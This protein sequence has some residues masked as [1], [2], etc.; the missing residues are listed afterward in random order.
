MLLSKPIEQMTDK[1]LSDNAVIL[2]AA[3]RA[4][5]RF[6]H[7][8]KFQTIVTR[9]LRDDVRIEIAER[10]NAQL[11]QKANVP[12]RGLLRNAG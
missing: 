11:S 10:L 3:L 1:E 2:D 7:G 8:T 4:A 6:G 12:C 5:D 9:R